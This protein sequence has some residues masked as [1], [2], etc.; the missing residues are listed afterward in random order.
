MSTVFTPA[1]EQLEL[2]VAAPAAA[3]ADGEKTDVVLLER[4]RAALD[5]GY[6]QAVADMIGGTVTA[7][8]VRDVIALSNAG[9]HIAHG[10]KREAYVSAIRKEGIKPLT[11]EGSHPDGSSYWTSGK[12]IFGQGNARGV[13]TFDTTFFDYGHSYEHSDTRTVMTIALTNRAAVCRCLGTSIPFQPDGCLDIG[14]TIPRDAIHLLRVEVPHAP[15]F[16]HEEARANGR[17]AEQRMFELLEGALEEGYEA[18]GETAV[19]MDMETAE[20]H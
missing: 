5:L 9:G 19:L 8:R 3:A 13:N 6:C 17:Q 10:I 18:G 14:Q 11:P 2:P 4:Y 15:A 12:E 16:S 1:S 20:K 7:K